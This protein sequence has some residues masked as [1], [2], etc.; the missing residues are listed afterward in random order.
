MI[1]AFT[2]YTHLPTSVD[3]IRVTRENF[4]ELGTMLSG[5]KIYKNKIDGFSYITVHWAEED[6]PLEA[7]LGQWIVLGGSPQTP[8]ASRRFDARVMDDNEFQNLYV[9]SSAQ[10]TNYV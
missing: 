3:A 8:F 9:E 1:I 5:S 10:V 6:N 2:T 7:R 4:L